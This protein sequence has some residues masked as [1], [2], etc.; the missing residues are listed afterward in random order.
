LE[1]IRKRRE[2]SQNL[3]NDEGAAFL[4]ASDLGIPFLEGSLRTGLQIKDIFPSLNDVTVVGRILAVFPIR[5]FTRADGSKGKFRRLTLGDR[6]GTMDVLL[7]DEKADDPIVG[8]LKPEVIVKFAHGYSRASLTGETELHIG[9]RGEVIPTPK[10]E[11]EEDY[12][13]LEDFLERIDHLSGEV[14]MANISGV[15]E[16]TYPVKTFERQEGM[17]QVMRA[18]I[19]D[20]SGTVNV[21]AWNE[22]VEL[23][24]S[25]QPGDEVYVLR[26]RVRRNNLG[27]IEVHLN[28]RSRLIKRNSREKP[29]P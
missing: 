20:N 9:G 27:R 23:V 10:G 14:S 28:R 6:T 18:Q 11:V 15:I 8:E 2:E 5:E 26:G 25:L 16:R 3:L 21:V 7:W 17:G 4:I 29:A 12:P 1:L 22:D 13:K 24:K 19:R